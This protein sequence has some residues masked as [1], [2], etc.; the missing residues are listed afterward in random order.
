[1]Q[2]TVIK[3]D[4]RDRRSSLIMAC[5]AT[6]LSFGIIILAG[7][8]LADR[9]GS[10]IFVF[11]T[12]GGA[13]FCPVMAVISWMSFA[14]STGYLRRLCAYGYE[15]PK[16][17]RMYKGL[18][19]LAKNADISQNRTGNSKDSI[20]LSVICWV[21]AGGCMAGTVPFYMNYQMPDVGLLVCGASALV[22]V[23][24]GLHY[25]R[26]RL[27]EKYRDDVEPESEGGNQRKVR[28]HFAEGCV[29]I[30]VMLLITWVALFAFYNL[31]GVIFRAKQ[32][33]LNDY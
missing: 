27:R 3:Y 28:T 10:V 18:E 33:G 9:M 26:Q 22:W 16:Q 17:K 11:M 13:V 21:V 14:K 8:P 4:C 23:V 1:M 32:A 12:L 19:D 31:C 5:V 15:V 2:Y 30:L 24:L 29:T 6:I 25:F 7:S 20:A